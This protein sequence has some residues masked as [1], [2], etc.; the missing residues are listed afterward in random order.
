MDL[1]EKLNRI[2][3]RTLYLNL[4]ITQMILFCI[5][6]IIYFFFLR[7]TLSL[8]ELFHLKNLPFNVAVGVGFATAVVCIDVALMRIFPKGYFDDGGVNERIFRDVNVLHIALIAL[9]VA[10]IEEWLFR[11]VLQQILGVFWASLLF[12]SIHYRY[13]YKWIYGLLIVFISFGFGYL[14]E[15][16]GSMW[17]V[18]TAHFLI[19][20]TLGLLIRYKSDLFD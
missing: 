7:D 9:F 20:F 11:A 12:A 10:F 13:L 3:N 19:D 2:D 16:T 5:G 18:V 6:A 15:W 14:Y 1:R 4:I 8:R 17:S